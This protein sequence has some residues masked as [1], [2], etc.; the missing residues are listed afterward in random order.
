LSELMEAGMAAFKIEGRAKSVY[1]LANVVGAYRRAIDLI[2]AGEKNQK[3]VKGE[4]R[5]LHNELEK[6]LYHRGFTQGFM[7]G[8]GKL[9][10]N[11]DNSHQEPEWEFCG[12]V[13]SFE[14]GM[15]KVKVHNRIMVGDELEIIM[16]PYEVAKI[17][18]KEIIDAETGRKKEQASGGGSQDIILL[19][20][21]KQVSE[22]S[23][24]RRRMI[25]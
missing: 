24:L 15:A 20:V 6:K 2:A 19:P 3:E 23:V 17:K 21:K 13:I 7:F 5:K 8:Q 11:L 1:Y 12:Q 16:P 14:N 18:V 4:L 10:Q 22:F 25:L 9:A